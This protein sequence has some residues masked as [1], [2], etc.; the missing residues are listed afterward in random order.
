[1]ML[2]K[3]IDYDLEQGKANIQWTD[4][5]YQ[6]LLTYNNKNEHTTIDMTPAEATKEDK[7]IDVKVNLEMRANHG[8]PY[9]D[10]K[11]GDL[12]KIMLK[13]N[14]TRK[15]HSPLYSKTK[16]EV[17]TIQEKH[18]LALYEVNGRMRLRN[19]LLNP[20]LNVKLI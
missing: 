11:M 17:E 5:V 2:R 15:E 6:I 14:K 19:E 16:Y 3:R 7:H 12:L 10:I 20:N 9:P 4:Y 13:Y 8:R 1:M 18:G